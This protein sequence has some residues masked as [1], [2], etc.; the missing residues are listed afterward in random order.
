MAGHLKWDGDRIQAQIRAEIGR[1]ITACCILISNRAK[2]LLSVS[3]TGIGQEN[4]REAGARHRKERFKQLRRHARE[5]NDKHK[6]GIGLGKIKRVRVTKA[7]TLSNRR[8]PRKPK[9][10]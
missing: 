1:R 8:K 2:Q 10:E 7:G 9:A 5:F 6:L 4:E 3:G